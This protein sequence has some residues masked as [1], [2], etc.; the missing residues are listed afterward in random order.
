MATREK[1]E[2][3][4]VYVGKIAKEGQPSVFMFYLIEILSPW[5]PS[6]KVEEVITKALANEYSRKDAY[7][8][9]DFE[10]TLKVVNE[11]LGAL[12][13]DG[14]N[15]WIG[16][17]NSIVGLVEAGNLHISVCGNILGYLLR[18][19]KISSVTE[20]LSAEEDHPLKTFV[21]ITS[22]AMGENDRVIIGNINFFDVLSIDRLKK[23]T[24]ET[25]AKEAMFEIHRT[26][27]RSK[28]DKTSCIILDCVEAEF[29][30]TD[31]EKE[32]PEMFF[33]DQSSDTGFSKFMKKASPVAKSGANSAKKG[34]VKFFHF[35]KK[36]AA[37]AHKK[38]KESYGPKTKEIFAK[39]K[40]SAGA[41]IAK[42]SSRIRDNQQVKYMGVKVRPYSKRPKGTLSRI[43][44]SVLSAI[45]MISEK[46]NRRYLYVGLAI[47][48]VLIG[49]MKIRANNA[50]RVALNTEREITE[51][52]TQAV[53]LFNQAKDDLSLGKPNAKDEFA[54]ALDLA[55]KAQGSEATKNEAIVLANEITDKLDGLISATRFRN[56]SPLFS[57]N[58]NVAHSA[59]VGTTIY[60]ITDTGRIY[61]TDTKDQSPKL[62]ASVPSDAGNII[63]STFAD[64]QNILFFLT[65]KDKILSLDIDNNTIGSP[66]L[67][68]GASWETS[69]AIGAYVSNLYLL[70]AE[71]GTIW[72]HIESN[73]A[74]GKGS[75]YAPTKDID[76][77]GAID[78]TIDGNIYILKSDSSIAKFVKGS[79]DSSF[80]V[81][82]LPSPFDKIEK[83]AG[84]FTDSDTNYIYV[85]DKGQNRIIRFDKTGT[86]VNQY[87]FD[88][89]TIDQFFI[90]PRIQKM[91]VFSGNSVYEINVQ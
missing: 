88:G 51:S 18:K 53:D 8:L 50:N 60:S 32:L 91:W 17:L 64:S 45:Y 89:A 61:A 79:Y 52:Y 59:L 55:I 21:N 13:Q 66:S 83:P 38:W 81:K 44:G 71:S 12:S 26:L 3:R 65:D 14:D 20:G 74:F 29:K 58:G 80:S 37:G 31:K 85:L 15:D 5:H 77:K 33:L 57:V 16:N 84:I 7:T 47:I 67:A 22:G 76:L 28:I 27:R 48:L 40:N 82:A 4:F 6:T 41:G 43:M 69:A 72:K 34:L 70:D 2:D 25:S 63:S 23:L 1:L 49:Y 42:I 62:V 86:F 19:G 10:E 35:S 30:E 56:L 11:K 75:S 46:K 9:E 78:I 68:S 39:G 87:F 36:A 54:S 73:N 24:C 90:N